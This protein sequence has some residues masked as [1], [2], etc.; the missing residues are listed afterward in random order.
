MSTTRNDEVSLSI[1]GTPVVGWTELSVTRAI[2]SYSTV[3]V[4]A[5]FDPSRREIRELFRPFQYRELVVK[6]GAETV[7]TG[8]VVDILPQS[9]P[10]GSS[11][12][13]TG[14][15]L[16]AQLEDCTEPVSALPLK[17]EDIGLRGILSA[18]L[19]PLGVEYELRGTEGG[20]FEEVALDPDKSPQSVLAEVAKQRGFVLSDTPDGQLLCWRSTES[21]TPVV[22][23]EEGVPP[24]G[25]IDA[26]F[27]AREYY[28]EV[29]GYTQDKRGRQG[30]HH[31]EQNP[32]LE[33]IRPHAF[34]LKDIDPSEAPA[35]VQSK[36]GRMFGNM[37]GW[38]IGNLPTWRD[39]RGQLWTPN[40]TLTLLAPGVMVYQET[41]LLVRS[42]ELRADAEKQVAK[43][44]V[45][46]LGA[47]SG[48]SP[49][50]L[51][52]AG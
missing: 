44:D 45:V 43:L 26:E 6:V 24:L 8:M 4:L 38:S 9:G 48:D 39:P 21:G 27:S 47:F 33:R 2:D 18:I 16:P 30:S 37:A 17:F 28:S 40:T 52:W 29:T 31:T 10:E 49:K 50:V 14:Y 15:A 5:P 35:A 19:G 51:P 7:F 20:P 42:V 32:W 36:L 1:G 3:S 13:V 25:P 11:V 34:E 12:S 41:E 23:F 46:M 22:R